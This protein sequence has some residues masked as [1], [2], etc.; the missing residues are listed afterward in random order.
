M[1]QLTEK[2]AFYQLKRQ[3]QNIENCPTSL[4]DVLL[5]KCNATKPMSKH[6][7]WYIFYLQLSLAHGLSDV[8]LILVWS[9]PLANV[10]CSM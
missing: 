1:G 5:E 8:D 3:I 6:P 2:L 9:F 4:L 10:Q 7:V